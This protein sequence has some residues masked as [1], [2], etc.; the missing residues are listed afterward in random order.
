MSGRAG[1]QRNRKGHYLG[2]CS[3]DKPGRGKP[4]FSPSP[5]PEAPSA[6]ALQV[7]TPQEGHRHNCSLPI[8][9]QLGLHDITGKTLGSGTMVERAVPKDRGREAGFLKEVTALDRRFKGRRFFLQIFILKKFKITEKMKS[10]TNT[11]TAII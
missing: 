4:C 7:L 2:G 9:G 3:Q 10:I 11:H 5:S 8:P 6:P 1:P